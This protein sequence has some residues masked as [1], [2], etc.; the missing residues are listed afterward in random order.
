MHL[1]VIVMGLALERVGKIHNPE[2]FRDVLDDVFGVVS[3]SH[4]YSGKKRSYKVDNE[5]ALL[6]ARSRA[7][8]GSSSSDSGSGFATG[9]VVGSLLF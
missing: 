1:D 6:V 5:S 4:E 8:S 9:F 7:N 3:V 2:G